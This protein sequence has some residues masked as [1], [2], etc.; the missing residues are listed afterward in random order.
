MLALLDYAQQEE[1]DVEVATVLADGEAPGLAIAAARGIATKSIPKRADESRNDHE[2][3]IID[4][5]EAQGAELI[6][7]AGYMRLVSPEFCATFAG[8]MLN[9]HPSL[10]P[11]H[12]GLDTH[13]K[14]IKAG[15]NEHGCS[16]HLVTP[17]MDEGPVLGQRRVKV[18]AD[19]TA[20]TLAA[21]VLAEEHRLYPLV[22][23]A[24]AAGLLDTSW[25]NA[26]LR[27]G[28]VKGK[29][30]GLPYPLKWPAV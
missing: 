21:R 19:D 29:I 1:N 18:R 2:K 5:L 12:K 3:R 30:E 13:E 14:A 27:E 28:G 20:E 25:G 23:G 7:L 17:G 8:R 11:R 22:V 16:V 26:T 15:D 6:C 24:V 9:I 4:A 10:L